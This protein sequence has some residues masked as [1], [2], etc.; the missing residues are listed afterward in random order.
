MGGQP[1]SKAKSKGEDSAQPDQTWKKRTTTKQQTEMRGEC[2]ADVSREKT[3]K[4][5]RKSPPT[6]EACL[7]LL[8]PMMKPRSAK[9][10]ITK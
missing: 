10:F 4:Q 1:V 3:K 6:K 8:D 7:D 5:I 2:Q 9:N